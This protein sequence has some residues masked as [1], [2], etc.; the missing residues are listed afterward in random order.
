MIRAEGTVHSNAVTTGGATEGIDGGAVVGIGVTRKT[1][2]S[3]LADL[4]SP[5]TRPTVKWTRV[6]E[7]TNRSMKIGF[8]GFFVSLG[9]IVLS[10]SFAWTGALVGFSVAAL[11]VY[12]LYK[13][14]QSMYFM[15]FGPEASENRRR[16]AAAKAEEEALHEAAMERYKRT[17]LCTR[18][19]TF[20]VP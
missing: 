14:L 13:L 12:S 17:R 4:A 20:Y 16:K 8:I 18:C 3:Q 15:V 5:P 1:E 6:S 7:K 11:L 9:M 10:E 2:R 19:G